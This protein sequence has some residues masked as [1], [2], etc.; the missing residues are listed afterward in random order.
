[1]SNEIKK[2]IVAGTFIEKEGK[3]LLIQENR[4]RDKGKWWLPAG[5][6]DEG[7][8]IKNTAIRETLEESGYEVKLKN[9][10]CIYNKLI[11]NNPIVGI[12][13]TAQIIGGNLKY[14]KEEISDAKWFTYEEI[15][16]MKDNLRSKEALLKCLENFK[17]N[18][19]IDLDQI[20]IV[21]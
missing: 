8:Y 6:V 2:E 18:N 17:N 20:V 13:F 11:N 21:N 12:I 3:F 16:K 4:G 9:I 19:Y 10:I 15:L 14:D 5:T 1:M 7:E